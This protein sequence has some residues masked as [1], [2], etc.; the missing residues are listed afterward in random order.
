MPATPG[1]SPRTGARPRFAAAAHAARP[2]RPLECAPLFAGAAS[3]LLVFCSRSWLCWQP[4]RAAAQSAAQALHARRP[5]S[6]EAPVRS[7]GVARWPLR[8]VRAQRDGHGREQAAAPTCGSSTSSAKEPRRADS[9][10]TPR[11]TQPALVGG[12]QAHLL[13]VDAL[14]IFASVAA[15]ARAAAKPRR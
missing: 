4:P 10:R 11:T 8:R 2:P 6:P 7:A 9:R 15:A 12:R 5:R 13:P 1:D 14:G 3:M